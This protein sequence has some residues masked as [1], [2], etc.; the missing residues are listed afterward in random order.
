MARFGIDARHLRAF[1]NA[2]GGEAALLG[3][4]VAPALRS[5]NRERRKAGLDDLQALAEA[6]QELSSLLFWRDLR[7]LAER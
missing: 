5:R 4:L 2:A 6:T 1:R 7:N 3:Q